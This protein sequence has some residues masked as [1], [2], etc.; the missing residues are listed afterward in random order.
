MIPG[1]I[2]NC[3][4]FG[5]MFRPLKPTKVS[6]PNSSTHESVKDTKDEMEKLMGKKLDQ[7]FLFP[8]EM[9]NKTTPHTWMGVA[10]NPT[11]P[12]AAEVFKKSLTDL[13][14]RRSSANSAIIK[15]HVTNGLSKPSKNLPDPVNEKDETAD[16]SMNENLAPLITDGQ[17][18]TVL[19]NE[20]SSNGER[21][22]TLTGRYPKEHNRSRRGTLTGEAP[23]VS[24]PMYREDIFFGGSLKKI[25]QYQSHTSIGY[26]MSVTHLPTVEDVAEEENSSCTLCPEAVKRTLVTMLDFSLLK[27]PSFMLL[28]LSGLFSMMGFFAPIIYVTKRAMS[29]GMPENQALWLVSVIGI[30]NTVGRVLCGVL[31]SIEGVNALWINNF[32]ITIGGL[33]TMFSGLSYAAGYQFTYCIIF[34]L[35]IGKYTK[36]AKPGDKLNYVCL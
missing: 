2:L 16:D 9:Q 8:I 12:T 27:S 15:S 21:R 20:D 11:Y 22:H 34:G 25:P 5:T 1:L 23:K 33:A 35:S 4:L 30:A 32:A 7:G 6:L 19:V 17:K 26:H 14:M 3:I 10:P 31:S 36:I 13:E 24:R 29:E 18:I 28:A